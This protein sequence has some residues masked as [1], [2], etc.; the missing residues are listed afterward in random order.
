MPEILTLMK[1]KQFSLSYSRCLITST[2]P[3]YVGGGQVRP[4]LASGL[5]QWD[6]AGRSLHK[7]IMHMSILPEVNEHLTWTKLDLVSLVR[8]LES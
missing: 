5:R 2:A 3:A 7:H 8:V 1:A 4:A 6:V